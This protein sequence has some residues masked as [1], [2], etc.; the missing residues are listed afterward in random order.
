MFVAGK[1][2]IVGEHLQIIGCLFLLANCQGMLV[3]SPS[4][5]CII[6]IKSPLHPI[7]SP[8]TPNM[9]SELN[10]IEFH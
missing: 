5:P 1:M 10:P 8:L 9:K 7:Q 6:T 4:F 2:H 3:K